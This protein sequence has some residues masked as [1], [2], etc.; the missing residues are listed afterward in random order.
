MTP[1]LLSEDELAAELAGE[2]AK[3]LDEHEPGWD[4][5]IDEDEL[6][7]GSW[8]YCVLGQL[9]EDYAYRPEELCDGPS[10]GFDI[11]PLVKNYA[12]LDRAWQAILKARRA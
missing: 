11:G 2:G 6:D 5:R 9:Y 8:K 10:F 4:K 3:W 12:P 1:T 7:M